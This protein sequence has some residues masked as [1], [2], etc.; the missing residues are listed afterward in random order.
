MKIRKY[1]QELSHDFQ[2]RGHVYYHVTTGENV[3]IR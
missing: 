2:Q 1:I 3:T